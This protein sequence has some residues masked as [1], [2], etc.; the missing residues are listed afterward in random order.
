MSNVTI[1]LAGNR[2]QIN[3]GGV[4]N[5]FA[6]NELQF[7]K[8]ATY[9]FSVYYRDNGNGVAK[10]HRS[11]N[12]EQITSPSSTDIDDLLTQLNEL[13]N[14]QGGGGGSAWGSITGDL[15]DQED[16]Q[17]VLNA[18]LGQSIA[19]TFE[20]FS[21]LL[22]FA[23]L[24]PGQSY[25]I[26][27]FQ[28]KHQID[29]T[30]DLND[31]ATDETLIVIA[32]RSDEIIKHCFSKNYSE[33][34]IFWDYADTLCED[35]VTPRTGKIIY[36][37][38]TVNN[39]ETFWDF[40]KVQVQRIVEA[41]PTNFLSIP[42]GSKNIKIAK[43]EIEGYTYN[44]IFVA[45]VLNGFFVN[46]TDSRTID[47]LGLASANIVFLGKVSTVSFISP[48]NCLFTQDVTN[49][50]F[51]DG[52]I[53]NTFAKMQNITFEARVRNVTI[54]VSIN[55]LTIANIVGDFVVFDMKSPDGSAWTNTID[56]LGVVTTLKLE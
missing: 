23:G 7:E 36:R 4:V 46:A 34:I 10:F 53:G 33:D 2:V 19:V 16:L 41:V 26:T 54:L 6:L 3:E 50:T 9:S 14:M 13:A 11:Y 30:S 15:E 52:C 31:N 43:C 8:D 27:N 25:E 35:G 56:D 17:I 51:Q 40:R 29:G 22:N 28:T 55:D 47:V 42:L 20:E 48:Q 37:K 38:D 18:K 45:D 21:D 44:D 5:D 24:I 12:Y 32:K 1:A 39:I 49:V